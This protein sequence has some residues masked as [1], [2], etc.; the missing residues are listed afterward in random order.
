MQAQGIRL[1]PRDEALGEVHLEDVAGSDV[2]K[3]SLDRAQIIRARNVGNDRPQPPRAGRGLA[4][5][6]GDSRPGSIQTTFDFAS[7]RRA[8]EIEAPE[9]GLALPM[10]DDDRPIVQAEPHIGHVEV[11]IGLAGQ[12]LQAR[13]QIVPEIADRPALKRRSPRFEGRGQTRAI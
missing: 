11:A 9:P 3:R 7:I 1:A 8:I 6:R 13:G 5:L 10:V 12:A 4:E 2:L